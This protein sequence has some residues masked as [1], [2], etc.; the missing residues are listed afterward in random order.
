M[1]KDAVASPDSVLAFDHGAVRVL[2]LNRP[3]SMN[4]IDLELREALAELLEAAGDD[5]KVRVVVL[6]GAAGTF[7]SG[8]DV[9]TMRR[10][11][12]EATR[13]RTQAVQRIIRAI[14]YGPKPVLAAVEGYAVGAGA[15]LALACDRV[16]AG[17]DSVFSMGFTGVGLAGDMGIF[18]SLPAR[19]GIAVARQLML[20]PQQLSAQDALQL[21]LADSVTA[22][23]QALAE[24]IKDASAIAEGPPLA[25]AGIRRMLARWPA[26]PRDVL[27]REVDLQARLMDTDDYAEAIVAFAERR[28]PV[29]RGR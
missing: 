12:A 28:R 8:G 24:A 22:P 26:D 2:S 4:A 15:A 10:Q 17:A 23:G 1:V 14:W 16:V 5:E 29:F 18:A 21:G 27:E 11:G 19:A 13:T 9:S 20:L 25:L 7:C 6:T 3:A